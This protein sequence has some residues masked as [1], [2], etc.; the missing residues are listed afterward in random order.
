LLTTNEKN[1]PNFGASSLAL[2]C[3]KKSK[4]GR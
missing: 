4:A 2:N 3:F 1:A